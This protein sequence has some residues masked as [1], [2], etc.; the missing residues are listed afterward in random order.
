MFKTMDMLHIL[1]LG[2]Y[3]AA[4]FYGTSYVPAFAL[5]ILAVFTCI[6]I[7]RYRLYDIDL[8]INR[9]LV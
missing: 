2:V 6:A 5:L 9:T 3:D 8:L 7:L 4:L 1:P